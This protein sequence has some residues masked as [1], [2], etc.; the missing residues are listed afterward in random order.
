MWSACR[1]L[2]DGKPRKTMIALSL[3][4][5]SLLL[6]PTPAP[7]CEELGPRLDGTYVTVCD[8]SVARVRDGLGNVRDW[9]RATNTVTSRS[10]GEAPVVVR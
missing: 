8:G 2:P 1:I 4:I 5:A 7:N 10:A 9:D 3:Y 6:V